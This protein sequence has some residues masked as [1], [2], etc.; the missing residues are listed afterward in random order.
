[1][2]IKYK[3]IIA[4]EFII[5]TIVISSGIITFLLTYSYNFYQENNEKTILSE[6]LIKSKQLDLPYTSALKNKDMDEEVIEDL[7]KRAKSL[8]YKKSRNEFIALIHSN[9]EVFND[10]YSY[11]KSMGYRNDEN[12]FAILIGRIPTQQNYQSIS[13]ITPEIKVLEDDLDK[14]RNNREIFVGRIMSLE[15]Q[16]TVSFWVTAMSFVILVVLRFIYYGISWSIST[17]RSE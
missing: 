14:L 11:V 10:M 6:I 9:N 15:E 4:R 13:T 7:Y 1:M 17:L 2:K 8:G 16:I 12:A 3:K 5:F